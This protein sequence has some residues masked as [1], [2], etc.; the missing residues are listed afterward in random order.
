MNPGE[1]G[2]MYQTAA[3]LLKRADDACLRFAIQAVAIPDVAV[4]VAATKAKHVA[5]GI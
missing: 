4:L 2:A 3:Q 1:T 5:L